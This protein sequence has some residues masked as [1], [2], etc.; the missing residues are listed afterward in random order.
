MDRWNRRPVEQKL[1]ETPAVGGGVCDGVGQVGTKHVRHG[2]PRLRGEEEK[3]HGGQE[4]KEDG[5]GTRDGTGTDR[6][7]RKREERREKRERRRNDTRAR[8]D[9][10]D[11]K[12]AIDGGKRERK[13]ERHANQTDHA[14]WKRKSDGAQQRGDYETAA[15]LFQQASQEESKTE[16]QQAKVLC[17]ASA[18][19]MKAG[20]VDLALDAAEQAV[21]CNPHG[22]KPYFRRGEARFASKDFRRSF[23]DFEKAKQLNP[24]KDNVLDNCLLAAEEAMELQEAVTDMEKE[25]KDMELQEAETQENDQAKKDVTELTRDAEDRERDPKVRNVLKHAE[26]LATSFATREAAEVFERAFQLDRTCTEAM[27]RASAMRLSIGDDAKAVACAKAALEADVRSISAYIIL[28]TIL[29]RMGEAEE[30]EP[31]FAKAVGMAFDFPETH[32]RFANNLLQQGKVRLAADVLRFALSGGPEGK[33]EKPAK[34]LKVH[35]TMGYV[36]ALRGYTAEPIT[37]FSELVQGA[38]SPACAY[39]LIRSLLAAGDDAQARATATYMQNLEDSVPAYF[40]TDMSWMINTFDLPC[41]DQ[42]SNRLTLYK[43]F[44]KHF[45][46]TNHIPQTFSLPDEREQWQKASSRDSKQCWVLRNKYQV[47]TV[48]TAVIERAADSSATQECILQRCLTDCAQIAGQKFTMGLF[49]VVVSADPLEAY[50]LEEGL[51]YF[52]EAEE[53]EGRVDQSFITRSRKKEAVARSRWEAQQESSQ[54]LQRFFEHQQHLHTDGKQTGSQTTLNAVAPSHP[55]HRN[56]CHQEGMEHAGKIGSISEHCV[57]FSN[58]KQTWSHIVSIAKTFATIIEVVGKESRGEF[59]AAY[60]SH[61]RIPKIFE[62]EVALDSSSTPWLLG[63]ERYP[64]LEGSSEALLTRR[65]IVKEAFH[66]ALADLVGKDRTNG[67][68]SVPLH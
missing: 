46:D 23:L 25:L 54:Q 47:G 43:L 50:I 29:E 20:Y 26:Q 2:Q 28:G 8:K 44:E 61:L 66:L 9:H 15:K 64:L 67:T 32:V 56:L 30:A 4:W 24:R 55:E 39:L 17:N 16:E 31:L 37:I 7:H 11:E 27:T 53:H 1:R 5:R 52:A 12:D 45:P 33:M 49:V 14:S 34:D 68:N 65:K 19:W 41:W 18:A 42:I 58:W 62:L 36:Q 21:R 10:E 60:H 59:R 35:F 57:H 40:H 3:R 6:N 48:D 22:A 13:V 38:P 63:A 51:V